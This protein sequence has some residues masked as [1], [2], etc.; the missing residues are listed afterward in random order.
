MGLPPCTLIDSSP[1]RL[2]RVL[3]S[4]AFVPR[5]ALA[6]LSSTMAEEQPDFKVG[7]KGKSAVAA[8]R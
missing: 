4:A 5:V 3:N 1:R 7:A 8:R 2:K 6:D